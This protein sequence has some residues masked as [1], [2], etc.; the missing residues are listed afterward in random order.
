MDRITKVPSQR[1]CGPVIC[2]QHNWFRLDQQYQLYSPWDGAVSPGLWD[3][4][5]DQK[6]AGGMSRILFLIPSEY[7]CQWQG[8]SDGCVN[9]S[10][11]PRSVSSLGGFLEPGSSLGVPVSL[12]SLGLIQLDVLQSLF[13]NCWLPY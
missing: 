11:V 6:F 7:T 12:T 8:V 9:S 5:R 2:M 3:W 1:N 13:S 10:A 4:Y